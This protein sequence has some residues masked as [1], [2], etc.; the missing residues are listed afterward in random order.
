MRSPN[1]KTTENQ[2]V[3]DFE[4]GL[5][6]RYASARDVVATGV[7]QRGLKRIAIELDMA[8]SN[9]SV[10]LSDDPSRHFSLDSA[11]RYME[12]TGDYTPIYYLVE[13]FLGDKRNTKQ[14]ALE[15]IQALGPELLKLLTKA[16]IA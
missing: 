9:L 16:G 2:M 13:K 6:E 12:R 10:Q 11:E 14:A 5:T 3:L 4:P 8:P 15:Q 7:Y 1:I